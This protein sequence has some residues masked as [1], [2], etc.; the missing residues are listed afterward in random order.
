MRQ[1]QK[2]A[3]EETRLKIPLLF[4]YD[5]IHGHRT[6]FP[7]P[8]AEAASWDLEAIELSARI[9]AREAAA[10]GLQWTFAP[11]VDIARDP[12]WGRVMEGAGED[13]YLGSLIAK[14]RVRGFQGDTL[15]SPLTVMA[16]AKH[17]AAYGAAQAGRD[18]H[19]VNLGDDELYNTYLPPFKAALDAGV[20]TFMSS[21]NELN[22]V[23]ATGN[24]FLMDE[25]LRKQWNFGG[26]VV[27]DYTSI[28]EMVLHGYAS[29]EKHAGQ[30]ALNAG[31][32]MDMQGSV[33][34]RYLAELLKE[35]K[36]TEAEIDRSVRYILR[37]K[38]ELGLFDDPYLYCSN[39]REKAEIL[40][41]ENLAAARSVARKSMVLLKNEA[42]VLPFK[43]DVKHIAVVG[44]L[45]NTQHHILGA[46]RAAGD[47]AKATSLLQALAQRSDLSFSYNRGC[48][49]D[50]DSKDGFAAA[51]AA[52]RSAD[53]VLAVLGESTDM[54]GE[55]ASRAH[56]GLP[57]VQTELLE[58]LAATGKPV[59]VVLMNGRPLVLTRE[60]ELS[61]AMLEAWFGGTQAGPAIVDV[62][63][64]EYNPSGKLPMTFPRTLGQVP[65]YYNMKN[66]GR[67]MNDGKY[68]SKY[69]DVPNA[70]LF[71]FGFGLSYT[72]FEYSK[73]SLSDS[74][75]HDSIEVNVQVSNT[76]NYDGEEVVQLYTH[77][78]VG[79]L[80]RPVRE[81]KAFRKLAI[82]RGE[83][84]TVSFKLSRAELAY[85]TANKK[86]ETEPGVF[87]LW[88][89]GSS[90]A[91][92]HTVFRVE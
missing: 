57:G 17:Y 19:T 9:A 88:L 91:D 64:G 13:V 39:E 73:L 79:S 46:W 47:T 8:L 74:L 2:L 22:G 5:V 75:L 65:V 71:P 43:A 35:G 1:L 90:Q 80:T 70:P 7:M 81:L 51:V 77:Q 44:P 34:H 62:L 89:G 55:A 83:S 59:V 87:D 50:T 49:I 16:C 82:P 18:Y 32:D 42:N 12:R 29:D 41:P 38:F 58:A 78:R 4:G 30:L 72:T 14:A 67:P 20:G 53:V 15:A 60:Y 66:T 48:D 21:F 3:V 68:T 6:I 25:V 23:P 85:Y 84:R 45:A 54:S 24:R 10:S 26:F 86:F 31:I 27:T 37:K 36:I 61:A 63:F 76:G 92:L 28:N 56:I 40:T 11:M 69:L 33:Y 52:A